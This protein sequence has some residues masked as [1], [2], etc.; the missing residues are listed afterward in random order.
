MDRSLGTVL[1]PDRNMNIFGI[2]AHCGSCRVPYKPSMQLHLEPHSKQSRLQSSST[3]IACCHN[4]AGSKVADWC[5]HPNTVLLTALQ[6]RIQVLK[7]R[8]R[9]RPRPHH[10]ALHPS[11]PLPH[12]FASSG[13]LTSIS[14]L[15]RATEAPLQAS[16]PAH[17]RQ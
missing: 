14:S 17:P 10:P 6:H 3:T 7:S 2:G 12:A 13:T 9:S 1:A 8:S 4:G 5:G 15:P 16:P 11:A